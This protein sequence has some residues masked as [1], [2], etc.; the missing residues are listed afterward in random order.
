MA[1]RTVLALL[2]DDQLTLYA[3]N[4]DGTAHEVAKLRVSDRTPNAI[5]SLVQGLA[6]FLAKQTPMVQSGILATKMAPRPAVPVKRPAKRTYAPASARMPVETRAAQLLAMVAQS[7]G[8]TRQDVLARMGLTNPSGT[9]WSR[10][11]QLSGVR[12]T[13]EGAGRAARTR[14]WPA[15]DGDS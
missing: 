10:M 1:D 15:D 14:Y 12:Q 3:M 8:I 13:K 4:G 7:P 9:Q 2:R 5:A 6:P 11:V